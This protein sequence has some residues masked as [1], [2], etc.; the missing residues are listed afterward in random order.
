MLFTLASFCLPPLLVFGV[1]HLMTWFDVFGI[2]QRAFWKRVAMASAICHVLLASG[3]FVF[4]YF[5]FQAHLRL[6]AEEARFGPYLFNRSDFWR[7]MTIFDTA[8]M[9]V[10]I[11]LFSLLDRAGI[12]PPGLLGWTLAITF[13]VGTLQWSLVGGAIGA[14]LERFFEG[15]KTPEPED[16][17][18]F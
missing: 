15:L 6:E 4:S 12:N 5:D 17:E 1:Y 16:E 8:P 13:L 11:V 18:W 9:L 7:L 2:N 10:I 14:L 3:F